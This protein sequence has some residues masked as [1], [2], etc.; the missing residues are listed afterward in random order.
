MS[1]L[2]VVK[3]LADPVDCH[4]ELTVNNLSHPCGTRPICHGSALLFNWAG[5][6]LAQ[7]EDQSCQRRGSLRSCLC[8]LITVA[9]AGA[10]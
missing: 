2:A 1:Q 7:I 10:G 4:L 3:E 5:V 8:G 9:G 6:R